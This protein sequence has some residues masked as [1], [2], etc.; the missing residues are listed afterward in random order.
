LQIASIVGS[1]IQ[2]LQ[3]YPVGEFGSRSSQTVIYIS[4]CIDY[5][6]LSFFDVDVA[7]LF[8]ALTAEF[9]RGE[10]RLQ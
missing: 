10:V 5:F 2:P 1:S 6:F 8:F 4:N 3:N 9:H 7:N